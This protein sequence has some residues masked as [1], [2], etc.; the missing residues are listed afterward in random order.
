M[1]GWIRLLSRTRAQTSKGILHHT[2][3]I[4]SDFSPLLN[5]KIFTQRI[6]VG[7]F[8]ALSF[9]GQITSTGLALEEDVKLNSIQNIAEHAP[10][11]ARARVVYT[12][13]LPYSTKCVRPFTRHV[14]RYTYNNFL[15]LLPVILVLEGIMA[16]FKRR[17]QSAVRFLVFAECSVVWGAMRGLWPY[18]GLLLDDTV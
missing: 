18:S 8:I 12:V 14:L 10:F 9:N 5:S 13:Y 2:A 3:W 17:Y 4:N 7:E 1:E 11:F 16:G 6:L 15:E